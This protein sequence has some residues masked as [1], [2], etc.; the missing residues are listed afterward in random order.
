M[1]AS[2]NWLE[3]VGKLV[4]IFCNRQCVKSRKKRSYK[5]RVFKPE[6]NNNDIKRQCVRSEAIWGKKKGRT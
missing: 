6:K 4:I 1:P 2:D 3:G 5:E